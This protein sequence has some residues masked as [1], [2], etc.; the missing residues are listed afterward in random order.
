MYFAGGFLRYI[1]ISMYRQSIPVVLRERPESRVR[2]MFLCTL[3]EAL[4]LEMAV[5]MLR[6]A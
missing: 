3:E 6:K 2:G 5:D 1:A 4:L